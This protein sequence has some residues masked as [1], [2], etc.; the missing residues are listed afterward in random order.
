[1][2]MTIDP[3]TC[4]ACDD[5]RPVCPTKAVKAG[6]VVYTIKAD[7]C[8]ECEGHADEPQCVEVCEQGSIS[9]LAA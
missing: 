9:P 3:D 7:K 5:C 4:I 8:T 6:P 2:A 1:M